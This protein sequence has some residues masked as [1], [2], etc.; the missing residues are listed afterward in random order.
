M[1]SKIMIK[2]P[3]DLTILINSTSCVIIKLS[4]I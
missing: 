3:E 2:L 4:A 1:D